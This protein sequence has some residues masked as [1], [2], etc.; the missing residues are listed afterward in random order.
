[1]SGD[2]GGH[3]TPTRTSAPLCE[4]NGYIATCQVPCA[5]ATHE[6]GN[7]DGMKR[8]PIAVVCLTMA[9]AI[10]ACSPADDVPRVASLESD[11][12]IGSEN[13]TDTGNANP[14]AEVEAA[15][16]AFSQCL[17]D[18]GLDVVDPTFDG[19]V[20]PQLPTFSAGVSPDATPEQLADFKAE[21]ARWEDAHE[22]CRHHFDGI[23]FLA[24]DSEFDTEMEAATLEYAACM[25][26]NGVDM[27]DPVFTGSGVID[28]GAVD[29][30]G[31]DYEAAD[32]I[33]RSVFA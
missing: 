13:S 16:I 10:S 2:T 27:P 21:M 25:R 18:E 15:F 14:E 29:A 33:C 12:Q 22:A 31:D 11:S 28:F 7:L 19:R 24:P 6:L 5:A 8:L 20:N 32:K 3:R 17:R 26:E 23:V 30:T 4:A 9:L 1:M